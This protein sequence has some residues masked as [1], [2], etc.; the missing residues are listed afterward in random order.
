MLLAIFIM[1]TITIGF[2]LIYFQFIAPRLDP[3]NKARSFI[4]KNMFSEAIDEYNKIFEKDPQDITTHFRIANLLLKLNNFNEATKHLNQILTIDKYN[5]EVEKLDVLKKLAYSYSHLDDLEKTLQIYIDILQIF[6]EDIDALYHVSFITLG[7]EFFEISQG[8][9]EKLFTL[10]NDT[11]EICYGI[12]ILSYQNQKLNDALKFFQKAIS[13]KPKSDIANLAYSFTLYRKKEYNDALTFLEKNI[14]NFNQIEAK[15]ISKRLLS[16]INIKLNKIDTGILVL[17]EMLQFTRKNGMNDES[18]L[19]LYDLGFTYLLKNNLKKSREYW[20]ELLDLDPN[21]DEI[22]EIFTMLTNNIAD[23][24]NENSDNPFEDSIKD[25]IGSSFPIQ[26]LWDL[27]GLKSNKTIDKENIMI[28]T[29]LNAPAPNAQGKEPKSNEKITGKDDANTDRIEKFYTLDSENFRIISN[30]LVSKFGY[31]VDTILDTYRESDGVDFLANSIEKQEVT[32]I[33]VRRWKGTQIGEITL[34]N[35]AQ[36]IN[37][38]KAQK[39]LFI[40]TVELTN[41]AIKSID[42]LTKVSVTPPEDLNRHL[43]GLI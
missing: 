13:I 5:Y 25:W 4:K 39:G 23:P 6:P 37:D 33:W 24:S 26:F 36:A 1:L 34:R 3:N 9:F 18:L 43:K 29:R 22:K 17:E 27:S 21:Y 16:F 31:K 2:L 11:F 42:T 10:K 38:I 32:L 40:S 7:Q 20:K 28:T 15:F 35:F 30:R 19:T 12:G 41:T 14:D 8:F